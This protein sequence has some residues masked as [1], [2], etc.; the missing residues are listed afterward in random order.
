MIKNFKKSAEEFNEI[1]ADDPFVYKM[2]KSGNGLSVQDARSNM[3]M[4]TMMPIDMGDRGEGTEFHIK[5]NIDT[6]AAVTSLMAC[7]S[8]ELESESKKVITQ[9]LL[10]S[11]ELKQLGKEVHLSFAPETEAAIRKFTRDHEF[12][13]LLENW[14]QE[15]HYKVPKPSILRAK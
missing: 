3:E 4:F 8:A 12:K 1:Y 14:Q 11:L 2:E 13:Q 7:P 15:M 5:P 10:A 9:Y 6:R